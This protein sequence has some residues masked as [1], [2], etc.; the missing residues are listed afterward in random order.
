MNGRPKY[1]PNTDYKMQHQRALRLI[2]REWH[3]EQREK[4]SWQKYN[5]DLFRFCE[6]GVKISNSTCQ[7]RAYRKVSAKYGDRWTC[8]SCSQI[9][10]KEVADNLIY[11]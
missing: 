9:L 8:D 1:P 10:C 2:G 5:V 4:A 11:S 7:T 3:V 6:I